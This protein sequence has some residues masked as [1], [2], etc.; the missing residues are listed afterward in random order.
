MFPLTFGERGWTYECAP[1][2][3]TV[4]VT[5]SKLINKYFNKHRDWEYPPGQE[6][7]FHMSAA[8]W[9]KK[10]VLKLIKTESVHS[11]ECLERTHAKKGVDT[12][13]FAFATSCNCKRISGEFSV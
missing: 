12:L 9:S 8:E 6:D 2:R 1:G 10:R 11:Q 13:L 5:C 3:F 7:I 4:V